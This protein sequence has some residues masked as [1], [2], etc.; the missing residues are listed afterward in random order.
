MSDQASIQ[1]QNIH[2]TMRN[3]SQPKHGTNTI[4]KH[5]A[6]QA[7]APKLQSPSQ[8]SYSI[9]KSTM[10]SIHRFQQNLQRIPTDPKPWGNLG[11]TGLCPISVVHAN[12]Q[13]HTHKSPLRNQRQENSTSNSQQQYVSD[14]MSDPLQTMGKR[15]QTLNTGWTTFSNSNLLCVQNIAN[16]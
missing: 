5:R 11:T 2:P 9:T 8:F 1:I 13:R 16:Q 15:T 3:C 7:G 14:N 10:H 4:N 12:E 6:Q